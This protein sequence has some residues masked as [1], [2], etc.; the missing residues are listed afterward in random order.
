MLL[1]EDPKVLI[2][3][4]ITNF[5]IGPDKGALS[6]INESLSTLQETRADRMR[7][8]ENALRKLSRNLQTLNNQ[9]RETVL[10]QNQS[11]HVVEIS[12]LDTKKFRTA[13]AVNDLE[14]ENERLETELEALKMRLAE[15]E[16]QGA[17]GGEVARREREADDPTVL[18]LAIY[19]RLGIEAEPDADGNFTKAIIRNSKKGDVH[20]VNMDPRMSKQFYASY[21]WQTMEG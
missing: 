5:N 20:V 13:K 15:L 7:E 12:E 19:R 3:E 16:A 10:S 11:N 17:E 9:H 18:R 2:S 14:S 4:T 6:R 21:F 8:S 1:D